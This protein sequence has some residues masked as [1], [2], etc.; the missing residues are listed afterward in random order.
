MW[1]VPALWAMRQ[2]RS[3]ENV[4]WRPAKGAEKCQGSPAQRWPRRYAVIY[5]LHQ[6]TILNPNPEWSPGLHQV[7]VRRQSS[8]YHVRHRLRFPRKLERIPDHPEKQHMIV[9][10]FLFYLF[11]ST[12]SGRSHDISFFIYSCLSLFPLVSNYCLYYFLSC[13]CLFVCN[14]LISRRNLLSYFA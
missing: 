5:S 6:N 14:H 11:L 3:W 1:R 8:L 13:S 4:H 9:Q 2:T 12:S 7:W 10:L